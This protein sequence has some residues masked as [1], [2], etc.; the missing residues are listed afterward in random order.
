MELKVI[1]D[2]LF[3]LQQSNLTPPNTALVVHE[4]KQLKLFDQD[5]VAVRK[6]QS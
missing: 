2:K 4:Y 6:D 3:D 1:T 5:D